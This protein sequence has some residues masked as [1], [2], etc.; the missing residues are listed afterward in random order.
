[1]KALVR[2][3]LLLLPVCLCLPA[4]AQTAGRWEKVKHL[5]MGQSIKVS[6]S[7][8]RPVTCSFLQADDDR[9]ACTKRDVIFFIPRSK[10][11]VFSRSEVKS[12]RLSRQ[13]LSKLAGA[14][15]GVGAGAGI[16][17]AIDASA[18]DKREEGHLAAVVFGL[19]GAII[20]SGVGESTDFLAGPLI[21]EA[22]RQAL[23][24]AP[25]I[26]H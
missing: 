12:V 14:A 8:R 21:Y 1:M 19:V 15:I 18:D 11:L 16:G 22:P 20:G 6:S 23:P 24:V 2:S 13:M 7:S 3:A 4:Y 26:G 25:P 5:P 9:L 10:D 17:A